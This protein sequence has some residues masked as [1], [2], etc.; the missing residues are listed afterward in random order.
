MFDA[1]P[2]CTKLQNTCTPTGLTHHFSQS[3]GQNIEKEF[4]GGYLIYYC[5]KECCRQGEKVETVPQINN[6]IVRFELERSHAS[7]YI[8]I[9]G[10][11]EKLHV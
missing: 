11:S 3:M 1:S 6:A 8:Y 7:Y 9:Q 5:E 2:F 4:E 10:E